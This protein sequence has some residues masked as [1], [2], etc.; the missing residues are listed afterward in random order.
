M[1]ILKSYPRGLFD[2]AVRE[3]MQQYTCHGDH[4]ADQEFV[5]KLD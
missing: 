2:S 5:F 4:L 1:E 3:A